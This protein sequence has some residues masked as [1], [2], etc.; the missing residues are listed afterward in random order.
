MVFL[1]AV[2]R[3]KVTMVFAVSVTILPIVKPRLMFY[4]GRGS[5]FYTTIFDELDFSSL[6]L[7]CC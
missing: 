5:M 3:P 4:K 1:I 2:L 7:A 6:R